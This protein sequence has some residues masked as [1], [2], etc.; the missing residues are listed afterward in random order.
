[1]G[2]ITCSP[3]SDC[4]VS[5]QQDDL[6]NSRASP[7]YSVTETAAGAE[8]SD[9]PLPCHHAFRTDIAPRVGLGL[10]LAPASRLG[11][12]PSIT[13]HHFLL[14]GSPAISLDAPRKS[15]LSLKKSFTARVGVNI[16]PRQSHHEVALVALGSSWHKSSSQ[17]TEGVEERRSQSMH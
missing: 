4:K 7:H 9:P 1:M 8:F 2:R 16:C 10:L 5:M 12:E 15:E 17:L 13:S 11:R 3:A 14:A 6:I